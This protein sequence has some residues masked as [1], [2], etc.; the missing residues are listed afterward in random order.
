MA[1]YVPPALR[2]QQGGQP[3]TDNDGFITV[4]STGRRD[5][6]GWRNRT[7]QSNN[8]DRFGHRDRFDRHDRFDR[9]DRYDRYSSYDVPTVAPV[10]PEELAAK[11]FKDHMTTKLKNARMLRTDIGRLINV[12]NNIRNQPAGNTFTDPLTQKTF[13]VSGLKK[14]THHQRTLSE[15]LTK[16]GQAEGSKEIKTSITHYLEF[17]KRTNELVITITK[18]VNQL[19]NIFKSEELSNFEKA[20]IKVSSEEFS[21]DLPRLID[22]FGKNHSVVIDG[23]KKSTNEEINELI[24]SID[25]GLNYFGKNF[26]ELVEIV[27][28]PA[29]TVEK[30]IME[31]TIE[32][33]TK[34][35]ENPVIKKRLINPFTTASKF[36]P[37]FE[38]EQEAEAAFCTWLKN[39]NPDDQKTVIPPL[40]FALS[41]D[42]V[43][44]IPNQDTQEV[45]HWIKCYTEKRIAEARID[46]LESIGKTPKQQRNGKWSMRHVFVGPNFVTKCVWERVPCTKDQRTWV[47][48]NWEMM[49]QDC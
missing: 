9:Y 25:K 15:F 1:K 45:Q 28:Q 12:I 41:D 26:L 17:L 48:P 8:Y 42:M 39:F 20:K 5:S 7:D 19:N 11:E 44:L 43:A 27:K 47:I 10:T 3:T 2:D 36:G 40:R 37:S 6:S 22:I 32:I 46:Y 24:M 30:P 49:I 38:S 13:K 4:G 23:F 33:T 34:P 21:F 31:P 35:V 18:L 14:G 29:P 16:W